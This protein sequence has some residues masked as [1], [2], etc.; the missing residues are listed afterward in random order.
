MADAEPTRDALLAALKRELA[1]YVAN[2]NEDRAAQVRREIARLVGTA[3]TTV[4]DRTEQAVPE[5]PRQTR[6]RT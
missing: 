1:G 4:D 6:R 3:E 2:G 5:R